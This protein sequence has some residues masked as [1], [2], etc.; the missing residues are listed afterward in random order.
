ME[1]AM[2]LQLKLG[3]ALGGINEKDIMW[4]IAY[5]SARL[6]ASNI[7]ERLVKLM[8]CAWPTF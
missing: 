3:A 2:K 4:G 6:Q 1:V 5:V 8:V 7:A